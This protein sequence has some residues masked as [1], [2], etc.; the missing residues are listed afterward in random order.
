MFVSAL[1]NVV[2]VMVAIITVQNISWFTFKLGSNEESKWVCETCIP[3]WE[4]THVTSWP[5]GKWVCETCV[6]RWEYINMTTQPLGKCVSQ[7][8]ITAPCSTVECC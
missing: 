2:N 1:N 6:P 8:I 7:C 5:G 4:F 3:R